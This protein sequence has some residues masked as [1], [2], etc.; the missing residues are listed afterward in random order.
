MEEVQNSGNTDNVSIF[1]Q[2]G[3]LRVLMAAVVVICL[4]MVFFK[5]GDGT[6]WYVI[7][8]HVAPALVILTIWVLLFDLLMSWLFMRQ[9]EGRERLHYRHVLLWNASLLVALL[10]FWL[11]FFAALLAGG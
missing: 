2:V 10:A 6:G 3:A 4:L 8:V 11:P 1:K 7:P 5:D 9:K